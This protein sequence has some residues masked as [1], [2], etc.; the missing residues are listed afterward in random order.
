MTGGSLL[1]S[2]N[3]FGQI[4]S[5]H[6]KPPPSLCPCFMCWLLGCAR[7]KTL[8]SFP[9]NPQVISE[10]QR[11]TIQDTFNFYSL[12]VVFAPFAGWMFSLKQNHSN[13]TMTKPQTN[14]YCKNPSLVI[15]LDI[16]DATFQKTGGNPHRP[17]QGP[18]FQGAPPWSFLK[19]QPQKLF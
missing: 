6:L 13:K 10:K 12:F 1:L 5:N 19:V 3:N 18:I 16:W 4:G 7:K 17:K 14:G 2:F 15:P 11:G 9:R 8:R